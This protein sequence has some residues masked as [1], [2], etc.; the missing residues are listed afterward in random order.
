MGQIKFMAGLLLFAIFV[1]AVLGF[2]IGYANDNNAVVNLADDPELMQ[3][4]VTTTGNIS[5]FRQES[6]TSSLGFF[7]T[8]ESDITL[9]TTGQFKVGIG[10][11]L[12]TAE[13]VI[14]VG[15]TKVF[16]SNSSFG[17]IFIAFASFLGI[18]VILYIWKTLKGGNPD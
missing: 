17:F 14:T 11:L 2:S 5:A 16:G 15:Y 8:E 1:I 18:L 12:K 7:Q 6:N 9:K 13:G 3:L 4:N 10:T